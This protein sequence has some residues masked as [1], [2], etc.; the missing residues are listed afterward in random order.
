MKWIAGL[1]LILLLPVS[2]SA[3]TLDLAALQDGLQEAQMIEEPP[4]WYERPDGSDSR[5]LPDGSILVTVSAT[6]DVT[7]GGDRRKKKPV[8]PY[9]RRAARSPQ[10]N[11]PGKRS[12]LRR[13]RPIGARM[14]A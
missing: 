1:T 12:P 2:L 5:V 4:A 14:R 3:E 11:R 10:T 13:K 6:G 9:W 8:V 7:I